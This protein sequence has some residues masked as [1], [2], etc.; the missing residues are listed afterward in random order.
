MPS[1]RHVKLQTGATTG[2]GTEVAMNGRGREHVFYLTG[3]AGIS[4]GAV[5]PEHAPTPGYTGTW[6]AIGSPITLAASTTKAV[7]YTGCLG[8]V[9]ARI[10]TN[11]V[12]GTVD[13]DLFSNSG[14]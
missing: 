2:N 1:A 9:R 3:S 10:S 14:D 6:Q 7:A 11:V 8:Y 4:A 5:Q 13:V 12:G